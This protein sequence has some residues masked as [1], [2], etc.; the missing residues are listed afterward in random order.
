MRQWPLRPDPRLM[1]EAHK[2]TA[3]ALAAHV[4]RSQ[5]PSAHSTLHHLHCAAHPPRCT[6]RPPPRHG[7]NTRT[8]LRVQARRPH[9]PPLKTHPSFALFLVSTCPTHATQ[10]P[11]TNRSGSFSPPQHDSI[12]PAQG[13]ISSHLEWAP[14]HTSS[15]FLNR[16]QA[17]TRCLQPVPSPTKAASPHVHGSRSTSPDIPQHK[18]FL[19]PLCTQLL[20]PFCFAA[21]QARCSNSEMLSD[22]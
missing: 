17:L 22:A 16:P 18:P 3:S 1:T 7:R 8:A 5:T 12:T 9:A 20:H 21:R 2:R 15:I 4:W 19:P 11:P 10:H 13:C 6:F 14:S